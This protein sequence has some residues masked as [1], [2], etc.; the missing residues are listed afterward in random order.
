MSSS[1]CVPSDWFN[2]Q[3]IAY[4]CVAGSLPPSARYNPRGP[5][6]GSPLGLRLTYRWLVS[7]SSTI[8]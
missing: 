1:E 6:R 7:M 8:R 5:S 3:S 4:S 2:T